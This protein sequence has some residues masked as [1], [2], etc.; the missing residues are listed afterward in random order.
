MLKKSK[1]DKK[2][3]FNL[4]KLINWPK[5]SGNHFL[6]AQNAKNRSSLH[7]KVF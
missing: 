6:A 5:P 1:K 7:Y 3:C 4:C 2:N